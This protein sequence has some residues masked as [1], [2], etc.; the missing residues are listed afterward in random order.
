MLMGERYGWIPPNYRVS[1]RP[2]FDW[3][4]H[5]EHGHSITALEAYH[6]FLRKPYTPVRWSTFNT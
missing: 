5:F 3:V 1:D 6:G 4:N 2:Q